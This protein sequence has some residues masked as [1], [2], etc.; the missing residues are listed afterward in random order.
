MAMSTKRGGNHAKAQDISA[1]SLGDF[2][3]SA[4]DET[5]RND[6]KSDKACDDQRSTHHETA[7]LRQVLCLTQLEL[8]VHGVAVNAFLFQISRSAGRNIL[9][10]QKRKYLSQ[11]SSRRCWCNCMLRSLSFPWRAQPTVG[12]SKS[13][14]FTASEILAE[15]FFPPVSL[16]PERSGKTQ[17]NFPTRRWPQESRRRSTHGA[18]T[19]LLCRLACI[20]L[21]HIDP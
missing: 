10:A 12:H 1:A 11:G 4:Y 14:L 3:I 21:P 9:A 7:T 2:Y 15:R 6:H 17:D 20:A 8:L 13:R 16:Q 19:A 5:R 18:V